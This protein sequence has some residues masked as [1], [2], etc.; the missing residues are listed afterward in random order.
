MSFQDFTSDGGS[1]TSFYSWAG[2]LYSGMRDN[3][4]GN[5][6]RNYPIDL[7]SIP[8]QASMNQQ[9]LQQANQQ[10]QQTAQIANVKMQKAQQA[11]QNANLAAQQYS[12]NPTKQNYKL[13]QQASQSANAANQQAQQA[14]NISNKTQNTVKLAK[15]SA[16]SVNINSNQAIQSNAQM[17]R[18]VQTLSSLQR[19]AQSSNAQPVN[20]R[21]MIPNPNGLFDNLLK[22]PP[23]DTLGQSGNISA[24]TGDVVARPLYD[25]CYEDNVGNCPLGPDRE[26]CIDRVAT[27]CNRQFPPQDP[28][29]FSMSSKD[30]ARLDAAI[31]LEKTQRGSGRGVAGSPV[32]M[33]PAGYVEINS[34]GEVI[35]YPAGS[36]HIN[37]IPRLDK[38]PIDI[39]NIRTQYNSSSL[40]IPTDLQIQRSLYKQA[41]DQN[42]GVIAGCDL[43]PVERFTGFRHGRE[44]FSGGRERN[45]RMPFLL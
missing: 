42:P 36:S 5:I 1:S 31:A 43:I 21:S 44:T 35:S 19:Q 34:R 41:C 8:I 39:N 37:L 20:T 24:A 27:D 16:N 15:M 7:N 40:P 10:A 22:D 6:I 4:V 45:S 26:L 38:V 29:R 17:S 23:S 2:P 9:V 12:N 30:Q 18:S 28:Y 13:A 3:T 14:V 11:T 32:S 33:P 25:K